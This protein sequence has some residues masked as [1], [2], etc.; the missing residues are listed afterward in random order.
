LFKDFGNQNNKKHE[1]EEK[2]FINL[3]KYKLLVTIKDF[4]T[5]SNKKHGREEE[6]RRSSQYLFIN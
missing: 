4:V 2:L 6:K 1:R 5:Q 3:T